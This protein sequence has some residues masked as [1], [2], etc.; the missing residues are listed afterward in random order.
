MHGAYNAKSEIGEIQGVVRRVID[1]G[2]SFWTWG[3]SDDW[4]ALRAPISNALKQHA[5]LKARKWKIQ[6]I[7]EKKDPTTSLASLS[8]SLSLFP[9]SLPF[10][11]QA[12]KKAS[13]FILMKG[14]IIDKYI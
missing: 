13:T 6:G 10:Q 7:A 11:P 14:M 9:L 4:T 1:F 8:L 12:E 5:D 2:P 3:P